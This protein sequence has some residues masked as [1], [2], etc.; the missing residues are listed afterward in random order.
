MLLR[1]LVLVVAVANVLQVV[2]LKRHILLLLILLW[3]MHCKHGAIRTIMVVKADRQGSVG[4]VL[5]ARL[6]LVGT[7]LIHGVVAG[8]GLVDVG[9][10]GG[11]REFLSSI[12][13]L[14]GG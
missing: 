2:L 10:A 4:M 3:L 5:S 8:V 13:R 14:L 1:K 12:L 7:V 11:R 9:R 6:Q